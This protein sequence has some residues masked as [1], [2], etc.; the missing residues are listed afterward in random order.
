L[1]GA[2][3]LE[4][5]AA[6]VAACDKP[7]TFSFLTPDGTSLREQIVTIAQ[8]LYGA[9]G[10]DFLP[11]AESDLDRMDRLGFGTFPVCMAKTH[12]SLSHDPLLLNRPVGLRL[13]VRSLV[14]SPAAGFGVAL[15]GDLPR[16]P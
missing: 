7:A 1:G 9:G 13:P 6:V 14:P 15:R 16:L 3:A 4:L 12:L 10:V 2:G 5:A 8:R 11:Q